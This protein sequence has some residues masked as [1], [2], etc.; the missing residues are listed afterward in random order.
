MKKTHFKYL[1]YDQGL[2]FPRENK[3][4]KIINHIPH[5]GEFVFYLD[6]QDIVLTYNP[7][8][9]DFFLSVFLDD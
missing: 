9:Y 1:R 7:K 8:I 6:E 5:I 3:R 4:P 2:K